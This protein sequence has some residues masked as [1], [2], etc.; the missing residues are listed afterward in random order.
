MRKVGPAVAVCALLALTSCGDGTAGPA[1]H[2][3][4]AL[5]PGTPEVTRAPATP[6]PVRHGAQFGSEH[7]FDSGLTVDASTPKTFTPGETAYPDTDRA[8]SVTVTVRND[9]GTPYQLSRLTVRAL[10]EGERAP[11]L[12][13]PAQ[14]YTGIVDAGRDV[15]PGDRVELAF[16]FAAPSAMRSLELTVRPD[17]STPARVVYRGT[18]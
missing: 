18:V 6:S 1:A 15:S 9:S 8:V 7:R 12:Y 13:D 5:P 14:G 17:P 10:A 3:G 11:Q 16:A 4:G 2:G